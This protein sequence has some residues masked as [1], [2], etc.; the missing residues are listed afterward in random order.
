MSRPPP[1]P[2]DALPGAGQSCDP[3]HI[4]EAGWK[5]RPIAVESS[6]KLP[7][8]AV[9]YCRERSVYANFPGVDLWP[10]SRDATLYEGP[11]PIVAHPPCG[12]WGSLKAQCRHQNPDHARKAIRSLALYGGVLEHPWKSTLFQDSGWNPRHAEVS[13]FGPLM[14][15]LDQF[16][17]GHLIRKRTWLAIYPPLTPLPP[18]PTKR[19]SKPIRA[20]SSLSQ[21]QRETTPPDFAAWLLEIARNA[22]RLLEIPRL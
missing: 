9:L 19:R 10:A 6:R 16:D 3:S 21:K 4:S 14:L 15:L 12:P 2:D 11:S 8:I 13:L 7:T 20:Y 17:F 22:G 1:P 5:G 18:L